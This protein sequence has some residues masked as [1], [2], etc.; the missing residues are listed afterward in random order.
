MK[1]V[2]FL[3]F[4]LS[5]PRWVALAEQDEAAIDNICKFFCVFVAAFCFFLEGD[6]ALFKTLKVSKH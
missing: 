2:L 3:W 6:D 1:E 4:N 5:K